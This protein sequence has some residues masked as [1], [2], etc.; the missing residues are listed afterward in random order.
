MRDRCPCPNCGRD[1]LKIDASDL[2]LTADSPPV[3][4]VSGEGFPVH[5]GWLNT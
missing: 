1:M 2:Y 3:F 5:F 4:R